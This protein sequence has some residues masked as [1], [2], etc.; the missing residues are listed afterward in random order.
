MPKIE[1]IDK[2][3]EMVNS[4]GNEP[5]IRQARGEAV[6]NLS[7]PEQGLSQDLSDLLGISGQ[8]KEEGPK[9]ED[10]F[11]L[12]SLDLGNITAETPEAPESPE[13]PSEIPTEPSTGAP[14]T[15]AL[16]A[17]EIP[18]DDQGLSLTG[19]DFESLFK[20]AMAITEGQPGE[21]TVA[22]EILGEGIPS[23]EASSLDTVGDFDLPDASEM[24]SLGSAET[25][26]PDTTVPPGTESLFET[27]FD[28]SAQTGIPEFELPESSAE[29]PG[30]EEPVAEQPE[31]ESQEGFSEADFS[32]F[33][34]PDFGDFSQTA[35][36][37]EEPGM[38]TPGSELGS[39]A[40]SEGISPEEAFGE[41]SSTEVPEFR[42]PGISGLDQNAGIEEEAAAEAPPV[43]GEAVEIEAG[44]DEEKSIPEESAFEMPDV[45]GMNFPTME[46]MS[47]SPEPE[48]GMQEDKLGTGQPSG[49]AGDQHLD[50][51]AVDDFSLPEGGKGYEAA[52]FEEP[53]GFKEK[54]R[55]TP[56]GKIQGKDGMGLPGGM[57]ESHQFS[58]SDFDRIK[59]TLASLP[60]NLKMAVEELIGEQELFGE[61]LN[62]LLN[63]LLAGESPKAIAGIVSSITGKKIVLPKSFEKR[64]GTAFEAERESF[65]FWLKTKGWKVTLVVTGVVLLLFLIGWVASEYVIKPI[66]A[67]S[68][69]DEG[70]RMLAAGN[71]TTANAKF[72]EAIRIWDSKDQYYRFAEGFLEKDNIAFARHKYIALLRRYPG[73]ARGLIDLARLETLAG[74]FLRSEELLVTG[75]TDPATRFT[76]YGFLQNDPNNFEANIASAE[77]YLA[78]SEVDF[79]R[80]K[81]AEQVYT[82]I[83]QKFPDRPESHM[84]RLDYLIRIEA[85]A[86]EKG[87]KD[88]DNLNRILAYRTFLRDKGWSIIDPKVY[89]RMASYLIDKKEY[90]YVDEILAR[91]KE[92]N[93][94]DPFIY[95]ELARY[96][97]ATGSTRER[98]ALE[99]AVK[100][101]ENPPESKDPGRAWMLAQERRYSLER[102]ARHILAYNLLGE[103]YLYDKADPKPEKALPMFIAAQRLF[104]QEQQRLLE[105]PMAKDGAFGKIYYNLGVIAFSNSD[106]DPALAHFSDARKSGFISP[107]QFYK[108]GFIRFRKGDFDAALLDF[109]SALKELPDNIPAL[110][111]IAST[112]YR[113]RQYA[114]AQGYYLH[115]LEMLDMQKAA[116]PGAIQADNNPTH[117]NLVVNMFLVLNNLGC[118]YFKQST[119]KGQEYETRSLVMFTRAMQLFD[120]ISRDV[121]TMERL[122]ETTTSVRVGVKET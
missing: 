9:D 104:V 54:M 118:T 3:K 85:V 86:Q 36:G 55:G 76:W 60:L 96:Y 28:E 5:A 34:L 65:A 107:D 77:N 46:E 1:D 103:S 44:P 12:D 94:G 122:R 117:R 59:R 52:T 61:K 75:A 69:Y 115:L 93:P 26:E 58:Q 29:Q 74:N 11:S 38:E 39:E 108:T 16:S 79:T 40:F 78:W 97:K 83:A 88:F 31:E 120:A 91:A 113:K 116:I 48:E 37:A 21:S 111:A 84:A 119:V 95:F 121:V 89:T 80:Q 64:T 17:D 81:D 2:L 42:M 72:D 4:L 90:D 45:S 109:D 87:I 18:S 51:Y 33:K 7:A 66:S 20:D 56:T 47:A 14:S 101:F 105:L 102:T 53:A 23:A 112:E 32:S 106:F 30:A 35:G 8:T 114:I 82:F 98:E 68:L 73:D 100:Y 13:I 50:Q 67:M 92:R 63:A 10:S 99:W 41:G 71:Q 27:G 57:D 25:T 19:D 22:D 70:Y 62:I 15:N 6:E 110:F 49:K 43:M 24:T